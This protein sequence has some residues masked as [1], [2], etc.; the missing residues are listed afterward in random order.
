MMTND[1]EE[2]EEGEEG[3]DAGAGDDLLEGLGDE[4]EPE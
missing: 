3:E 4:I 1:D 2:K